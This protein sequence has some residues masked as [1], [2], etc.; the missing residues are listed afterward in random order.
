MTTRRILVGLLLA[1]AALWAALGWHRVPADVY[2]VRDSVWLR[3]QARPLAPGWHFTPPLVLTVRTYPREA[4]LHPFVVGVAGDALQSREGARLAASGRLRWRVDESGLSRLARQAGSDVPGALLEPAVR[5]A[6]RQLLA[7]GVAV[8]PGQ[9]GDRALAGELAP[10]MAAAGV[11]LEGIWLESVG[12]PEVVAEHARR[13]AA[14]PIPGA[15]V[16]LVGWDGADWNVIDPLLERGDLPHLASLLERGAR[17]RLRT[18]TPVLSPVVWTSVATGVGPDRHGI[19]DFLAVDRDSGAR[20][21]VTSNLRRVP[22]LWTL[23]SQR[24]LPVGVVAWWATWPAEE[25]AGYVVSDRIAYQLFGMGESLLPGPEGKTWPPD[26]WEEIEPLMVRPEE[27]G[28]GDVRPFARLPED[29]STLPD[30]DQELLEEFKVVL[31]ATHTYSEIALRL[32]GRG[33]PVL[34]CVYFEASDTAAHLFMP[35]HPPRRPEID[36][37]RYDRWHT[38]VDAVYRDLDQR[39]GRLL[40]TTGPE[41]SVV[42]VSDHGFR[43]GDN[44]PAGDARIGAGQAADWHRKYGVLVVAGRG[45]RPGTQV[46]EAS[47]LDVA[48]TVLALLGLPVPAHMQGRVLTEALSPEFLSAHPPVLLEE[49]AGA[50]RGAAPGAPVPSAEDPAIIRRLQSLGY[51][52]PGDVD[53]LGQDEVTA[54]NNRGSILLAEGR[55][56]EG[57]AELERGLRLA[58]E[59]RALRLNK[60]R[61]LRL[62]KRDDEALE[63]LEALRRDDPTSSVVENLLG[64]IHMDRKQLDR[65]EAAFRRALE[66]EPSSTG[67]LVSLGLLAERRGQADRALEF[68][69][70]AAAID[71]DSAEAF[72]NIGNVRRHQALQAQAAGDTAGASRRFAQAEEA[73]LQG[74]DA[75]PDFIGTYNNM[76]LVYQDT[77]RLEEAMDLYR[78]AL[79][80]DPEH[81]VVHNNL[82]SLYF[83]TGRLEEA[84]RAFQLAIAADPD[85]PSAYNNLG[86]V[87]GRLGDPEAE[88]VAYRKAVELD[89]DYADGF[90]NLGL[91]LARRGE[92]QGA[93]QA[94]L[95]AVAISPDYLSAFAALGDL[96]MRSDEPARAAAMLSRALE[97]NPGL[98]TLRNQLAEAWLAAGETERGRAEYRRSLETQPDQPAV[99]ERL[100]GL[101][102]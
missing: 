8:S 73:Y 9:E 11:T 47:V 46:A 82:G 83:A 75:D 54:Y 27:I 61:A 64:N 29:L 77:G 56:E 14:G 51:V 58:P 6:L 42:L 40:E 74:L 67:A 65:A 24:D 53:R 32:A 15:R 5:D 35:F 93:E 48:P 33:G 37:G 10:R 30:E 12:P 91:A 25:V 80:R 81:A 87:Q 2:A 63:V 85:Y 31:A 90:H 57:L 23:L 55:P 22:A 19:V 7:R 99:R 95:R 101:G 76:A 89:P 79:E 43:T 34:R 38:V 41:T 94:L 50:V 98:Y 96:Y 20:V 17:G 28:V 72:N 69:R 60:A 39:L 45:A 100:A 26:L 71:P 62:L 66:L 92:R 102:G 1:A 18:V 59:A 78:R 68:Y 86:A 52:G 97:I 88:L 3:V 49:A 70:R 13:S 16:L 44:R 36:A 4:A 84:H 21:P